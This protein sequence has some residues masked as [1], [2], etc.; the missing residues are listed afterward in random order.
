MIGYAIKIL[1]IAPSNSVHTSRWLER[2]Y[3][4]GIDLK[5]YDLYNGDDYSLPF[6]RYVGHSEKKLGLISDILAI[7]S[8]YRKLSK[9]TSNEKFDLI[10]LHWLFHQAPYASTFLKGIPI[11]ATSWGSDVQ[12]PWKPF[13]S[14]FKKKLTNLMLIRRIAKKSDVICCDSMAQKEILVKRGAEGSKVKIIYFGTDTE[15][16]NDNKYSQ[17]LRFRLG[18]SAETIL[19]LSNR[20]HEQIYD[21]P[22]FLKAAKSALEINSRLRF[23]VAG[24]G[25][26]TDQ[27]KDLVKKLEIDQHVVFPGRLNNEDFAALSASCDIYVSTSTSDGGLA[28]S[29]A[30]AMSSCTPVIITNFG[31]NS[32]WLKNETAGYIFEIG[33]S[34]E[35]SKILLKLADDPDLMKK[36]GINGRKVIVEENNART[37]WDKVLNMYSMFGYIN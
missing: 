31:E 1:F 20:N 34:D 23:V 33:D 9:I 36:L 29:T 6:E 25:S 13:K 15:K 27:L 4:S 8:H 30:E 11:V 37:E 24:S 18:A 19:V 5:I 17:D 12:V 28:A 10:H 16:F 35:L 2:T 3:S 26:L 21:I 22:T 7:F 14:Q 32:N